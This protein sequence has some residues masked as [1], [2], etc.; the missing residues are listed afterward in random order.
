M[1]EYFYDLHIHSALSPCADNDMTPNNIAGMAAIKGLSLLALTDHNSAKNC[2]AFFEACK[3]Q[4]IVA[5]AGMELSTAEDIHLVCLFEQLEDAM[6]FDAEVEKHLMPIKN[7]PE[8]FGEQLILDGEDEQIGEFDTLL[9]SAT[10]LPID[11][12]IELARSYGAHV[13]P[14]HIDRESNGIVAI[15]GDI[16]SEYGFSTFEL[17][18]RGNAE[19]LSE[20]VEELGQK[21]VLVCSDAHHLWDISEAEN[22]L[23]IDD[24]PYSSA[25]VRKK[26]L[27]MLER[28]E[29]N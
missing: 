5:I 14:A 19:K 12:A 3:Q 28:G 2:P 29:L 25:L 21:N 6:R 9:I 17:R 24:E 1:T 27:A 10:D 13:H 8:I 23:M 11:E 7:R 15:L 22:S 20:T 16:P 26:V 4:G 18:E